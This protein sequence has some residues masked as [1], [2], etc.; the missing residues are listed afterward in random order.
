MESQSG[1]SVVTAPRYAPGQRRPQNHRRQFV[2]AAVVLLSICA[3][4]VICKSVLRSPD[5]L[6]LN[7]LSAEGLRQTFSADSAAIQQGRDACD[8]YLH[9]AKAQGSKADRIAVNS[10]CPEFKNSFKVLGSA[11]V[12]G[13]FA[14][15]GGASG[16]RFSGSSYSVCEGKGGYSDISPST[17][18]RLVSTDGRELARSTLGPGTNEGSGVCSFRFTL[19]VRE[20]EDKYVLSVGRRGESDYTFE[21]LT[22]AGAINLSLGDD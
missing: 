10:Y 17:L 8:R 9:G 22:K 20:G 3:A 19:D 1:G 11:N 21:E 16:L 2:V 13:R 7:A 14:V 18:V 15:H 12:T 6:Y 5:R 4:G